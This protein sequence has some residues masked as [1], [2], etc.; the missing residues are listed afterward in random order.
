MANTKTINV[1]NLQPDTVY[2]VRGKVLFSRVARQTTDAERDEWNKTRKFKIDKNYT[3][4]RI[5][6]ATVIARDPNNPTDAEIY[7]SERLYNTSSPDV[8][9]PCFT[10]INKS[11]SLP[12]VFVLN[13][14]TGAYDPVT[15]DA[16]LAN[17]LDVTIAMRVFGTSGN[18]GVTM[19]QIYVNEPL[20]V[21]DSN[22]SSTVV[23]NAAAAALGIVFSAPA[24]APANQPAVNADDPTDLVPEPSP[25]APPVTAN[26]FASNTQAPSQQTQANPF[27]SGNGSPFSAGRTY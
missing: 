15:L 1:N 24:P 9:N 4:L 7:A 25:T 16:E 19:A 27:S 17:G 3:T 2:F 14:A 21:F 13:K 5:S 26:P 6:Q 11:P 10:A 12:D 22:R 20:R 23:T 8:V 18:N